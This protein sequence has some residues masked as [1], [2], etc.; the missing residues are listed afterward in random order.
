MK[1]NLNIVLLSRFYVCYFFAGTI[2]AFLDVLLKNGVIVYAAYRANLDTNQV[3]LIATL[4]WSLYIAPFF[5]FS[6]Q[7]GFLGDRY[8]KRKTALILRAVD[9]L[10]MVFAFLG[11]LSGNLALLLVLIFVKATTSTLFSPL[12]YALLSEFLPPSSLASASTVMEAG[13]MIAMLAGTYVGAIYGA[14]SNALKIGIVALTA[15][16]TSFLMTWATPKS[17]DGNPRLV[18]PGYNPI[19]T[20]LALLR[21]ACLDQRCIAAIL[22]LSWYWTLG[23]VYLSN[24]TLLV[25]GV[26]LG[27]E[28]MVAN[29][30]LTFTLG[31][32]SG[33]MLG[34]F[35]L[36]GRANANIANVMALVVGLAGL[37]LYLSIPD[38]LQRMQF[39][40]FCIASASGI[41][42]VH[43]SSVLHLTIHQETKARV[44]ASY[45]IL[46]ALLAVLALFF[47]TALMRYGFSVASIL[48]GFAFATIPITVLVNRAVHI[49]T[50]HC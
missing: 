34:S 17:A 1:K 33:L 18:S 42:A 45:N 49:E 27:D 46:S 16:G 23:A 36:H 4:S 2:N 21:L 11:F 15:V 9:C 50:S 7:A 41:Y 14:D 8:E 39:D 47:S 29:L 19:K 40:L 30:L 38:A 31:V 43:F 32:G 20:S 48:A 37:D 44:F 13:T 6:A 3:G 24:V 22:A 28:S 35:L 5:I 26:L 12:K 10:L 25:R